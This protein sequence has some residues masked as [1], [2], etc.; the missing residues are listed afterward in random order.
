MDSIKDIIP[1]VIEKMVPRRAGVSQRQEQSWQNILEKNGLK[2]ARLIGPG[3]G[4][5]LMVVDSPARLYHART[6]KAV[7]LR[8]IQKDAPEV[9]DITIKIGKAA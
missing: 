6:R 2:S 5:I 3:A 9:Q 4:K 8:Q 7:I 1:G